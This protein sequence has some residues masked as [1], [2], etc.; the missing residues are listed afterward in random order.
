MVL[1]SASKRLADE[2]A[3]WIHHRLLGGN[4]NGLGVIARMSQASE[5]VLVGVAP[6]AAALSLIENDMSLRVMMLL[7]DDRFPAPCKV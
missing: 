1:S 6:V 2:R 5:V 3:S 7:S 4:E